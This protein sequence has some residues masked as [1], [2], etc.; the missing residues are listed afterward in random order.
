MTIPIWHGLSFRGKLIAAG[1]LVQIA[2]MAILTWNSTDL[3]NQYLRTQLQE[4]AARDR[5]LFNAAL[6]APIDRKSVV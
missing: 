5:V 1:V 2:A 6:S 3:I 4:S